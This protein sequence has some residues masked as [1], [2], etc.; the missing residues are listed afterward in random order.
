MR[1]ARLRADEEIEPAVAVVVEE[2]R[3]AA[4]EGLEHERLLEPSV[5]QIAKQARARDVFPDDEDVRPTVAI[6]ICGRGTAGDSTQSDQI[7]GLGIA[8]RKTAVSG[9]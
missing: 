1:E 3:A 7:T 9:H 2:Q 8:R 6:V 4:F 5:P